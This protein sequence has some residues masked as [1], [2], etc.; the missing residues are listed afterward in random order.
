MPS[1]V[2]DIFLRAAELAAGDGQRAGNVV[3]VPAGC[4][5]V[6]AGDIHGHR[7]NLNRIIAWADLPAHPQRRLVVQEVIHGPPDA[8]TGQDRSVECLLRVAR[9][10]AS[11]PRQVVVLLGNHDIA[12]AGGR[13][14]TKAGQGVCEAFARGVEY[15]CGG[16]DAP[17]VL[18]AISAF[19]LSLPLAARC[20]GGVVMVH[21][22]PSPRRTELA[23]QQIPAGAYGPQSLA[24]GGGVYEWTWGRGHT[25]DQIA[26]L[27]AANDAGC[28][29]LGHEPVEEGCRVLCDQAVV[30]D[31]Q[32]DRGAVLRFASDAHLS[33]PEAAALA[34][35][36]AA[37]RRQ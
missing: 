13:E 25:P 17:A 14:I 28:F 2:A 22:L 35:P 12:Q 24:R 37:L 7:A 10:L 26:R 20:P 11:C 32:H 15:A 33:G 36:I 8:Q 3:A 6:V 16:V 23:G 34:T 9:L 5:V 27:A 29:V 19:L 1:P 21:S 31:S 18:E 30:L 4:E